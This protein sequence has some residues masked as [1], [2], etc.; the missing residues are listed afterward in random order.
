[1]GTVCLCAAH[2]RPDARPDGVQFGCCMP[3]VAVNR[4]PVRRG[5]VGPLLALAS[6]CASVAAVEIG[7]RLLAG[8]LGIDPKR[9][10][11]TR[12]LISHQRASFFEP[13]PYYGWSLARGLGGDVNYGF[14]GEPWQ[15]A[16]KPGVLRI[17]CIGG[18]TTAGGNPRGYYGSFPYFLREILKQQLGREIE[19][20]NCGISGWTS[21]EMLCAWFLLIQDFRPDLVIIHEAVNDVE[22]RVVPGFRPD[23]AHW[24]SPWRVPPSSPLLRRLVEHSDF[25]AWT[26][27]HTPLPTLNTA[28]VLPHPGE[29]T[30]RDGHLPR[31]TIEPLRRNLTTIGTSEE[32]L[33]GTVLLATLPPKPKLPGEHGLG[34]WRAGIAE[35]NQ[36]FRDLAAERAWMLAD[37]EKLSALPSEVVAS[38]YIDLVH[39]DPEVNLWKAR[40]IAEVLARN[41]KPLLE[42]LTPQAR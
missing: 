27:S 8:P 2:G 33:G 31:E 37:L 39:V 11:E 9:L 24:R 12:D 38:H 20:M 14:G 42:Q 32:G 35:H 26:M 22:P 40:Q 6:L 21:A 1:M 13:K 36:L 34:S 19:V 29:Y 28:T 7:F 17:A 16:R 30:F 41:W 4:S 10:S 15:L 18:S 5:C 25:A 23:Y 3:S